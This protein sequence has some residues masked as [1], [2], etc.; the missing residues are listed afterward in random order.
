MPSP[1][2]NVLEQVPM[3]GFQVRGVELPRGAMAEFELN[4]AIADV[5]C[6]DSLKIGMACGPKL[7]L[8]GY[9]VVERVTRHNSEMVMKC[10][11]A[12]QNVV[13][14]NFTVDERLENRSAFRASELALDAIARV[15]LT[16]RIAA[17]LHLFG[18]DPLRSDRPGADDII[19]G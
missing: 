7:V 10:F 9:S 17:A 6:L 5:I 3:N 19:H 11:E 16:Q 2:I 15:R 4:K 8:N 13:H 1:F 18:A 12:R 14:L